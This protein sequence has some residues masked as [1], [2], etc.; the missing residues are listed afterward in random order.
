MIPVWPATGNLTRMA[1]VKEA[2][3][4]PSSAARRVSGVLSTKMVTSLI[5]QNLLG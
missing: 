1:S 3:R 5:F 2:P 4:V